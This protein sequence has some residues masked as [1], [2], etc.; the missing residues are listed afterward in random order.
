MKENFERILYLI[1]LPVV[2]IN[3]KTK[4]Y[5]WTN[6]KA[7]QILN[8]LRIDFEDIKSNQTIIDNKLYNVLRISLD[9]NKQVI[10][11][12][13]I[14][15]SFIDNETNLLNFKGFF[16]KYETI[17]FIT[18]RKKKS[19]ALII[20]EIDKFDN[21][22]KILS[23]DEA[24]KIS[25]KIAEIIKSKIRNNI[26]II[27]KYN[28]NS[29]LISLV[30]VDRNKIEKIMERIQ[31]SIIDYFTKEHPFILTVS[32]VCTEIKP[33]LNNPEK[34][35]EEVEKTIQKL[36]FTMEYEKKIKQ[37]FITII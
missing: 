5:E 31:K 37:N 24:I 19:I 15:Q 30:E 9:N 17:Y 26:D 21:I 22:I 10:I 28:S 33:S 29:F 34:I 7:E 12:E 8:K 35:L 18:K 6:Q 11:F 16:L 3:N 20:T 23:Y 32:M 1:D 4:E 14:N 36:L 2:I 13:P 25:K 27:S